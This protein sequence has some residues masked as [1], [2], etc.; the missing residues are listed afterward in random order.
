MGSARRRF[1]FGG[2]DLAPDSCRTG[3]GSVQK[4]RRREQTGLPGRIEFLRAALKHRGTVVV[5]II[6][7]LRCG[8][9]WLADAIGTGDSSAH[10]DLYL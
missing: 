8:G 7:R 10:A 1:D 5:R 6:G 4:K 3:R 2:T 9:C